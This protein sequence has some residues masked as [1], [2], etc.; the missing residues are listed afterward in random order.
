MNYLRDVVKPDG[1]SNVQRV[2][3]GTKYRDEY[4]A[5]AKAVPAA[6]IAGAVMNPLN[7]ISGGLPAL[8]GAGAAM[9][10]LEQASGTQ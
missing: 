6:S 5:A 10:G 8:F 3:V 7:S 1:A 9:E 2:P 4:A